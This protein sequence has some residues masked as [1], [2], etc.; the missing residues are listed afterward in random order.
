MAPRDEASSDGAGTQS[1]G[2][3]IGT[4]KTL[5]GGAVAR[6]GDGT[7][8]TL[9]KGDS[10]FEGD[11]LVTESGGAVGVVL[12]DGTSLSLGEKGRLALNDYAYDAKSHSG[13]A[14]LSLESGS[15]A[16]VSGQIAKTAPDAFALKTP[17]MTIG[18]RG[19]GVAG[20]PSSVALMGERGGVAGEVV[21][22]TPGGQTATLNSVGAAATVGS[23]GLS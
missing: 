20:N 1:S 17:T 4:V 15:F 10:I 16:L 2:A 19:T 11:V 14:H 18:V 8:V 6:H 3:A 12:A 7:Q 21:I 5:T 13:D 23:G 22:T 9:H